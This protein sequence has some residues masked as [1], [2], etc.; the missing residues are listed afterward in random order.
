MK[1]YI[2]VLALRSSYIAS[3]E[4]KCCWCT[5]LLQAEGEEVLRSLQ[6][7]LLHQKRVSGVL[8]HVQLVH[9]FIT[10][11]ESGKK[12]PPLPPHPQQSE[13][14]IHLATMYGP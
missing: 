5:L 2:Q 6:P 13:G 14:N 1:V 8:V 4:F 11:T 10:G 3:E 12:L 7:L 9:N